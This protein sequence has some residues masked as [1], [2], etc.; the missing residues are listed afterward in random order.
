MGSRQELPASPEE[1]AELL[2]ACA[3]EG[4]RFRPRGG[5]TKLGWG[6]PAPDADVDVLTG[7]LD[8]VI[9]HNAGDLTAVLQ[10]GVPLAA[11]QETFAAAGQMLA[12]DP[13][14]RGP[15]PAGGAAATI[16]GIAATA[17]SGPLRH[18]YGAARDLLLGITV[19]L[20]DG[21]LARAGG[22]VIKN[23]AGYDLAKLYAGSFGT[24][25]LIVEVV[26]RLH[27]RPP[28]TATLVGRTDDAAALGRA[29]AA[30]AHAPAQLECLDAAWGQGRG[31]LLARFGGAACEGR[32]ASAAALMKGCGLDA[33]IVEGDDTGLWE[34]QRSRQRSVSGPFG[35]ALGVP[36]AIVRVSG[37]PAEL[38]RVIRA[39]GRAGGTLAGRAGLGLSW[40]ELPSVAGAEELAGRIEEVRRD[41]A[42]WAC[43]VLDAPDEVRERVDVWGPDRSGL[44]LMRRLKERFDP[45]GVCN[46][47]RFV[48]GI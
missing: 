15:D 26:V 47:G 14:L 7:N 1:A 9:E 20:S 3:D 45:A 27:P 5:G 16:G 23:V 30:L 19:A 8:R 28:R 18:R 2:R 37:L 12:L 24:L 4:L 44:A 29:A 39:A 31:E 10:A 38:A 13:P 43:T 48:G 11:A 25:G 36:G 41:L 42:P 34:R 33:G 22:R 17:D 32:A 6:R 35:G 21:T 46:P 40:I